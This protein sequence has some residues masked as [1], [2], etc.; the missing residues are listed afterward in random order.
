[1]LVIKLHPYKDVIYSILNTILENSNMIMI[2]VNVMI[3]HFERTCR[4]LIWV[5]TTFLQY[6]F[7]YIQFHI[8]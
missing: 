6:I 4:S 8:L 3:N 1:M 2:C 5:L 7:N